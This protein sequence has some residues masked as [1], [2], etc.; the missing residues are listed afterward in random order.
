MSIGSL[1][2][3][4]VGLMVFFVRHQ[5]KVPYYRLTQGQCV[6]LLRKALQGNLPEH[7]WHAFIGM[8]MRDS[9]ALENL[10]EECIFIDEYHV[11]GTQLVAGRLCM[12]F[13]KP[14]RQKLERLLDE[15]QHTSDY[16]A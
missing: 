14:G 6:R 10:R 3:V 12:I 2:V 1:F 7:E 13:D 16:L 8:S 11:K 4:L 5:S 15:W 9:E